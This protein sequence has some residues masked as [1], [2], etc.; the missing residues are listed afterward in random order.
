MPR[1]SYVL[2]GLIVWTVHFAGLYALASLDAQTL[3]RDTGVWIGAAIALSV[4]CLAACA[5]LAAVA[6]RRLREAG[7]EARR[8]MDQ[9]A[10]LGALLA[11]VAIAWQ[12][13][14]ALIV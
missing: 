4:A 5:A 10:L 8:L 14:P 2:G 3:F 13:L 9:L 11:V 7:G 12:T 6:A 1:W